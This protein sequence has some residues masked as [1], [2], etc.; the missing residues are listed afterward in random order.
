MAH[1]QSVLTSGRRLTL[2]LMLRTRFTINFPQHKPSVVGLCRTFRHKFYGKRVFKQIMQGH[3]LRFAVIFR[4]LHH[5]LMAKNY[6]VLI[7]FVPVLL[8]LVDY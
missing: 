8:V 7:M 3:L 4:Y 6:V 1:K 2:P 5:Y